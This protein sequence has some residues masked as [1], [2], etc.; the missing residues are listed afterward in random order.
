MLKYCM[1][2]DTFQALGLSKN[3]AQ[4]YRTLLKQGELT[5][6]KLATKS[7]VNRR[8][9]YDT[10]QRLLEKGLVFEVLSTRERKV[11]AVEPAKLNELV[12][13]KRRLLDKAMPQL[14]HLYANTFSDEEV[15][16]YKGIE[17]WKNYMRDIIRLKQDFYCIGGKGAWMDERV[18]NFFPQFIKDA[19][20]AKI[21]YFH[22]FDYEVKQK[23]HEII[24]YVGKEFKFLPKGYSAPAS[25]DFF[26]DR[27][28]ICSNLELGAIDEDS[29]FTVLVNKQVATAF[30]IWFQFMW[31]FCPKDS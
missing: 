27:V 29:T 9:V 13:E 15:F 11:R 3:E 21:E 10:I 28:Y 7:K 26:G 12:D 30:K 5:I 31:D 1:I 20:R 8:N 24:K 6:S 19:K 16:I 22:L 4:I 25:I 14:E 23:K 17:G 2:I 18:N